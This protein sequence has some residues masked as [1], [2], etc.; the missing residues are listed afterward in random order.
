MRMSVADKDARKPRTRNLSRTFVLLRSEDSNGR[1]PRAATL[2]TLKASGQ[3]KEIEFS[4]NATSQ[5]IT[6][7]IMNALSRLN[8]SNMS[9]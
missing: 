4:N 8:E 7:L 9:L 6:E 3:I 5:H 2:Q 1:I